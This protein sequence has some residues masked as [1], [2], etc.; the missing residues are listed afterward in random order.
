VSEV[1][2]VIDGRVCGCPHR[3]RGSKHIDEPER[4]NEDKC[5][6]ANDV[7]GD[8]SV[9]LKAIKLQNPGKQGGHVIEEQCLG[10]ERIRRLGVTVGKECSKRT[11][12]SNINL[13]Q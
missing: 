10:T 2:E 5:P 13:M 11:G 6:W 8:N 1:F 4:T 3:D 9:G 7:R 12:L